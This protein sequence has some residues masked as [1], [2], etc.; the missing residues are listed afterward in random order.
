MAGVGGYWYDNSIQGL[1]GGGE[2]EAEDIN[3][4]TSAAMLRQKFLQQRQKTLQ[5]QRTGGLTG[6]VQANQG[7]AMSP[8]AASSSPGAPRPSV[9]RSFS[10][11]TADSGAPPPPPPPGSGGYDGGE[12]PPAVHGP[13][14]TGGS[15][16]SPKSPDGNPLL[17][18]VMD[19]MAADGEEMEGMVAPNPMTA[20]ELKAEEARRRSSLAAALDEKGI[21]T[22]FDPG[23]GAAVAKPQFDVTSIPPPEMK[24]FLLNPSPKSAGM[25]ECRIIRFSK[26]REAVLE[27]CE[28]MNRPVEES[29]KVLQYLESEWLCDPMTLS[30]M[31]E[32]AWKEVRLPLGL[33][34]KLGSLNTDLLRTP[35]MEPVSMSRLLS[36]PVDTRSWI[37]HAVRRCTVVCPRYLR[38]R[39]R[40]KADEAPGSPAA[41]RMVFQDTAPAR[42]QEA[43]TEKS[44]V[45]V[46]LL[47]IQEK[48]G[49][50]NRTMKG[51]ARRF[52]RMDDD[53]DHYM[54]ISEFVNAMKEV[55]ANLTDDELQMLW[56]YID[57]DGNGRVTFEQFLRIFKPK[58][59]ERRRRAVKGLFDYLDANR[60]SASSAAAAVIFLLSRYHQVDDLKLKCDPHAL[61]EGVQKVRGVRMQPDEVLVSFLENF[62]RL[63]G[64]SVYGEVRYADFE[65][66]YEGLSAGIDSD[67]YF[68]ELL[69]KAWDLPSGFFQHLQSESESESLESEPESDREM[70][71]STES[72]EA[73]DSSDSHVTSAFL[74]FVSAVWMT[75]I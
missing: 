22:V 45:E 73:T 40:S 44:A 60:C 51:M 30:A 53:L 61:A 3:T 35:S 54:E 48:M 71:D 62:R 37:K 64:G 6:M 46:L 65:K 57:R 20:D 33:K 70:L 4:P 52:K 26:V 55:N 29:A 25:I 36:V 13:P 68:E 42:K 5:K 41:P 14:D 24:G 21:S 59:S 34:E 28:R 10:N 9:S 23:A 17:K 1:G 75:L 27:A 8:S 19:S 38:L 12:A 69:Q 39:F 47:R 74:L 49:R 31:S 11:I 2:E 56:R 15:M 18:S 16:S 7:I 50:E 67:V 58:L 43:S 72:R 63:V 66:Y 32:D